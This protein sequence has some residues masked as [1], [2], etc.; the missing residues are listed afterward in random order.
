MKLVSMRAGVTDL[1]S[2]TIS[3]A[4]KIS[5]PPQETVELQTPLTLGG[6]I[7]T[8]QDNPTECPRAAASVSTLNSIQPRRSGGVNW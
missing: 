2:T 3:F 8:Y 1:G 4:T 5:I 6:D 7:G